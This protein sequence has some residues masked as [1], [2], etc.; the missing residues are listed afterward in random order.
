MNHITSLILAGLLLATAGCG[1]KTGQATGAN[2]ASD[3]PTKELGHFN[4]DSAYNYVARQVNFGPRVPGT[5]SHLACGEFL[6]D[7]LGKYADTV[8]VQKAT[9]EAFNGDKLPLTNI[10]GVFNPLQSRRIILL[11]HWDTRPWA[12]MAV[13]DRDVPIPGANDGASGVAVLL[14]IARNLALEAPAVGV[15]IMFVD[16]EDYGN[17]GGFS[18]NKDTWCLGT[19]YWSDNMIPY[20]ANNRPVYG[21]LLDMVGGRNARFHREYF[22]ENNAPNPTNKIWSEGRRLG[23][24]DRFIDEIGGSIVDDHI[25]MAQAG[26]PT[27]NIVETMNEVTSNFPPTWHTHEDNMDNIDRNSL[28]AVGK[29]VLNVV[30]K[31]KPY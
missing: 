7:E 10:I 9:V 12:D 15:D 31:E 27:V 24:D 25:F 30:Y 20:T 3:T 17:S 19:Q 2:S 22:S 8:Y 14:E 1:T 23:F 13:E 29:T 18:D 26:I 5:S 4:A 16:G 6:I 11:A 21:I 28:N